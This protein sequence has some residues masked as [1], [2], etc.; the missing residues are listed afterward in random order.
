MAYTVTSTYTIATDGRMTAVITCTAVSGADTGY[1]LKVINSAIN[2]QTPAFRDNMVATLTIGPLVDFAS[3]ISMV[4]AVMGQIRTEIA[5]R[6]AD[7][8]NKPADA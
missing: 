5:R 3:V 6:R 8:L 2:A 1:D 4:A 7:I